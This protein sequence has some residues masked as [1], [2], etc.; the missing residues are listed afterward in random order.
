[1]TILITGGFGFVGS[2]LVDRLLADGNEV[3][4]VDNLTGGGSADYYNFVKENPH[5]RLSM[6]LCSIQK[7]YDNNKDMKFSN[8]F[9]LASC[10]GPAGILDR[11]GSIGWD[12]ITGTNAVIKF[13]KKSNCKLLFVSTSEVYGG[14]NA[15][16]CKED[17]PCLVST[18]PSARLEYALGK[19][20]SEVAIQNT[21]GLDAVIVRPFNIAGPRQSSYGGFVIPTF[22]KQAMTNSPI[23]V[24]EAGLQIR[25]FTHVEDIV[26]GIILANQFGGCNKVYNLGNIEN[27][28]TIIEIAFDVLDIVG[29]NSQIKF[30]SGKTIFGQAFEEAAN[31]FPDATLANVELGWQPNLS[32]SDIIRETWEYLR[33]SKS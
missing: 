7:F 12:I 29:S 22:V 30:T 16:L 6:E 20:T 5:P 27:K 17:M 15:G 13:A 9:H 25:A 2:H 24:F 4:V 19:L 8:I 28:R 23:T 32:L 18:K 33:D 3:L 21:T 26:N 10:V 14:G 31:K 1:M 11:S